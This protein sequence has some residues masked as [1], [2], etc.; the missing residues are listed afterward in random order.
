[1]IVN[2]EKVLNTHRN[3]LSDH[4][5][6]TVPIWFSKESNV[7]VIVIV[8]DVSSFIY[9]YE[10]SKVLGEY[11]L[12]SNHTNEL[13]DYFESIQEP[14]GK[15][16]NY[17]NENYTKFDLFQI[18]VSYSNNKHIVYLDQYVIP[19]KNLNFSEDVNSSCVVKE[20]GK[21]VSAGKYWIGNKFVEIGANYYDQAIPIPY[22]LDKIRKER[23]QVKSIPALCFTCTKD[24]VQPYLFFDDFFLSNKCWCDTNSVAVLIN[25][26]KYLNDI[27]I[28]LFN[29]KWVLSNKL[30]Q[31]QTI[32]G[33]L[34]KA[35][36]NPD[37]CI[38]KL[39]KEYNCK[40]YLISDV[41][42]L[43]ADKT[44]KS[45]KECERLVQLVF[46]CDY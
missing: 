16:I 9:C 40:V 31:Y 44:V 15:I 28:D 22:H 27:D 1:M 24:S 29:N 45:L 35:T 5:E 38:L 33:I 23:T 7:S 10:N 4:S 14:I 20:D 8:D 25:D 26:N 46:N 34:I 43:V 21:M 11:I 12:V 19:P 42:S 6:A 39:K 37:E 32:R 41:E 18:G 13:L 17:Y 2:F 36:I 30:G 3:V